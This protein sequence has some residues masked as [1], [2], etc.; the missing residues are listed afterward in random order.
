MLNVSALEHI[1]PECSPGHEEC[2][3]V[4]QHRRVYQWWVIGL[5]M[6]NPMTVD[7]QTLALIFGDSPFWDCLP[8][9]AV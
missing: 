6:L 9:F 8:K 3:V 4:A 5:V 7:S 1:A 2:F